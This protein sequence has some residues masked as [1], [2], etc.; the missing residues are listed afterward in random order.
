MALCGSRMV[1]LA[2]YCCSKGGRRELLR[3]ILCGS[4]LCGLCG[5]LRAAAWGRILEAQLLADLKREPDYRLAFL[6][7]TWL[8]VPHITEE[9]V[10]GMWRDYGRLR[11]S[12]IWQGIS[13]AAASI[14][15]THTENGW[16]PHLHVIVEIKPEAWLADQWDWSGKWEQIT[17]APIVDI[18]PIRPSPSG[19]AGAVREVAKYATKTSELTDP[20][21]LLEL[22]HAIRGRRL[23]S[24]SGAW[25]GAREPESLEAQLTREHEFDLAPCQY[26]GAAPAVRLEEWRF[27]GWR[28]ER[29][30]WRDVDVGR[31][32]THFRRPLGDGRMLDF[33]QVIDAFR[34][35]AEAARER[36]SLYAS[37]PA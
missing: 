23:A 4:R 3:G 28:F 2:R 19:I 34:S 17:G 26:C 24:T 33:P 14:E 29:W 5:H 16:H 35:Q 36:V 11:R 22:H 37:A 25:W 10:S 27:N 21:E 15:F 7:L 32:A 6:T 12:K 8:S 18:R 13:A 9:T 31:S 20:A 1:W 30:D